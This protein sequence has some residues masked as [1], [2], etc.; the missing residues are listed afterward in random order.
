MQQYL[1]RIQDSVNAINTDG[2]DDF[3][4]FGLFSQLVSFL[5]FNAFFCVP[6]IE[7]FSIILRGECTACHFGKIL[8]FP[9]LYVGIVLPMNVARQFGV[10]G[11]AVLSMAF[12][13]PYSVGI[14]RECIAC[15]RGERQCCPHP[16]AL[17]AFLNRQRGVQNTDESAPRTQQERDV[18]T[19]R[20]TQSSPNMMPDQTI[21][22]SNEVDFAHNLDKRTNQEMRECIEKNLQTKD[23]SARFC[24]ICFDEFDAKENIT[25][26]RNPECSHIFHRSCI[27]AWLKGHDNCPICRRVYCK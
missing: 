23:F 27:M 18:E 14:V 5:L 26:S 9:L 13:I 21:N 11:Y 22:E 24:S 8:V 12:V 2:H 17:S 7:T 19:T 16:S 1:R 6:I 10:T 4:W 20:D 3:P 15:Q 25:I